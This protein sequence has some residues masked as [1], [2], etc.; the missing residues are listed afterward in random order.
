[1]GKEAAQRHKDMASLFAAGGNHRLQAGVHR[2]SVVG[3]KTAAHFLLDFG[4]AQVSFGLVVGER[5]TLFGSG[6]SNP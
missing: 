1:M 2:C 5:H 6:R 4:R 3:A